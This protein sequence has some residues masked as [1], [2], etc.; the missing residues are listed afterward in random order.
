MRGYKKIMI[1]KKY[2]L[3]LFVP[4]IPKSCYLWIVCKIGRIL[5]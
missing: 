5:M 1:L 2:L 4:F 3:Y